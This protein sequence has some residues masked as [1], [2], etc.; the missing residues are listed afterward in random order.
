MRISWV[1]CW[2]SSRVGASTT[3][4]GPSPYDERLVD[5]K[6]EVDSR[7]WQKIS[8]WLVGEKRRTGS[9]S[10]W[11]STWTSMGIMYAR[12]LPEPA[13]WTRGKRQKESMSSSAPKSPPMPFPACAARTFG[14]AHDVAAAERCRDGLRLHWLRRVEAFPL[15]CGHGDLVETK[16][17]KAN[18]RTRN[19]CAC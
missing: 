9:N 5:R 17:S 2:T 18:A 3:A 15:Q 6:I 19:V 11:S 8:A 16:M 1:I 14:D 4:I 10:R 13:E 12:V 7:G